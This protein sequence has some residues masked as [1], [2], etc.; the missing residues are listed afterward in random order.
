MSPNGTQPVKVAGLQFVLNPGRLATIC[1][2]SVTHSA[3]ALPLARYAPAIEGF[4]PPGRKKFVIAESTHRPP[5]P[6]PHPL[7]AN[8]LA[9]PA[10][11]AFAFRKFESSKSPRIA[12][13]L[14][15]RFRCRPPLKLYA[16]LNAYPAPKS[17]S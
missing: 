1:C 6:T 2:A 5:G 7:M 4:S 9:N 15:G 11:A 8:G 17:C 3:P 12:F 10:P 16:I 14:I 13:A